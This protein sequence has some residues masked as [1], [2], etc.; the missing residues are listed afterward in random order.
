MSTRQKNAS[1]DALKT[2]IYKR[3]D[4][5]CRK[6]AECMRFERLLE[7]IDLEERSQ[8]DKQRDAERFRR[9]QDE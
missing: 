1:T 3:C 5:A 4:K 7:K 9:S 2:V 6:C 8:L